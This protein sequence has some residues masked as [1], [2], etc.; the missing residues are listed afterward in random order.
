[1][2][3]KNNKVW[4]YLDDVRVPTSEDWLVVRSYDAFVTQVRLN[5]LENF[6]LI[7]L[8]HD[9]GDTAMS[10]YYTN[11]KPNY[12]INYNNIL[13]K[14]GMD[15][16]KWLVNHSIETNIP[17][18]TVKV[19]SAN[20]IGVANMMGYINNYYKNCDQPEVCTK[21]EIAH[22][23]LNPLNPDERVAKYKK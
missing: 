18:P 10:E 23:Y 17:L 19:H 14:T 22:T 15:C 7:S 4:L 1:M 5:G 20:P 13:E 21:I 8:D 2:K 11:A 16:V 3:T 6:E 9:L 12:Q